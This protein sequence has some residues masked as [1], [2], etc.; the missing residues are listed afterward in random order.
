MA[1]VVEDGTGLSTATSYVSV[2]DTKE[3]LT[4]YG[5]DYSGYVE[6]DFEVAL[7]IA[8]VALNAQYRTH[9]LNNGDLLTATQILDWPRED[10]NYVSGQDIVEDAVPVEIE[11]ATA[12]L[13]YV[14]LTGNNIQP[15]Y[16][17]A[18]GG[19]QKY[20][21]ETGPIKESTT[22]FSGLSPN[23]SRDVYTSV[24]DQLSKITGGSD[25]RYNIR[26]IKVAYA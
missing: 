3:V 15:T 4:T 9:W 12:L 13:A 23:N 1:F 11:N 16:S 24:Q 17:S 18:S 22:Y 7:N 25:P 26:P 21:V 10:A 14:T 5:Y 19:I 6:N 2:S 8:T 20:A